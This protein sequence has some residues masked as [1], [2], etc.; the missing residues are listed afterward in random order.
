MRSRNLW[1]TLYRQPYAHR[2]GSMTAGA[3]YLRRTVCLSTKRRRLRDSAAWW[4]LLCCLTAANMAGVVEPG[5]ALGAVAR[6]PSSITLSAF[7]ALSVSS[8]ILRRKWAF[9]DFADYSILYDKAFLLYDNSSVWHV[10]GR[11]EKDIWLILYVAEPSLARLLCGFY[12][13]MSP[14][15]L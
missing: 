15:I 2:H 1:K 3:L 6:R 13:C 10:G 7:C 5:W 9:L 14:S 11:R 12:L 4:A 8:L